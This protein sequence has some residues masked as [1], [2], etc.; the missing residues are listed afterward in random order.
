M[1]L[2]EPFGVQSGLSLALDARGT[3]TAETYDSAGALLERQESPFATTFLM[4]RALGDRWMTV[5]VIPSE[6]GS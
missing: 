6:G 3:L 2:R 5:A 1:S 4:R